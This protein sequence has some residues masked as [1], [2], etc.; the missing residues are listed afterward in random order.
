MC[1]YIEQFYFDIALLSNRR[2]DFQPGKKRVTLDGLEP[3]RDELIVKTLIQRFA[4]HQLKV[5]LVLILFLCAGNGCIT[6]TWHKAVE[7]SAAPAREFPDYT[8]GPYRVYRGSYHGQ[9]T[10]AGKVYSEFLF[11]GAL[12]G[13]RRV[14]R[15]LLPTNPSGTPIISEGNDAEKETE[16]SAVL[17]RVEVCCLDDQAFRSILMQ[18]VGNSSNPEEILKRHFQYA[19]P[20]PGNSAGIV[21]MDMANVFT[22]SINSSVWQK[23]PEGWFVKETGVFVG[24]YDRMEFRLRWS[25]RSRAQYAA[26]NA[27]YVVTVLLDVVTSPFQLLGLGALML[28][29]PG[30]K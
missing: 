23:K 29:G 16:T 22:L 8:G 17:I 26:Y 6:T 27:F 19:D 14:L 1:S 9:T 11:P 4:L 3:G 5:P 7:E 10:I 12:E 15:L 2:I 28:T 20:F 21:V 30:A 25:Q 13:D 18:S 24:D